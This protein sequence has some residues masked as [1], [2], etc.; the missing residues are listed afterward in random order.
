MKKQFLAGGALLC[1]AFLASCNNDGKTGDATSDSDVTTSTTMDTTGTGTTAA[2]NNVSDADRTFMMDAASAGM[3]EVE[4]SRL[5][6]A[7]GS[8]A[9][10]K[11][12]ANMM[13]QDHTNANNEL[14]SLASQK[15]VMLPD[16]MMA[17]HRE[18]VDMLKAK[19]GKDFDKAFMD[20]MV[21]DHKEDVNKF[22][23]ASNNASDA[24]LKAFATKTLPTLR[25]HLDSATAIHGTMKK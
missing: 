12:Y 4:T 21:S 25:M 15:G 24:D 5:A 9:R 20:M 17:K 18:H 7:N 6:E 2:A 11:S 16:S 13:V 3:M 23:V 10:V 14:K 19:K 1:A 8:H 22:Q